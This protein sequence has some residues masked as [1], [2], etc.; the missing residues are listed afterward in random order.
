MKIKILIL[1]VLGIS[2]L[3]P[4]V[5][6]ASPIRCQVV[7]QSIQKQGKTSKKSP[8]EEAYQKLLQ[9]YED[10]YGKVDINDAVSAS[11]F[12]THAVING[13]PV[14]LGYMAGHGF[15]NYLTKHDNESI[16][17]FIAA[18]N[19]KKFENFIFLVRQVKD[20]NQLVGSHRIWSQ[21]QS[22]RSSQIPT[23]VLFKVLDALKE[24]GVFPKT[25]LDSRASY[26]QPLVQ[27]LIS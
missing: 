5:F 23:D 6:A 20:P 11:Q 25:Q 19:R 22:H 7:H 26:I 9:S 21:F 8:A 27:S 24:K 14:L 10:Q 1:S 16:R 12:L 2:F 13:D 3:T 15:K 18:L 17:F 4:P